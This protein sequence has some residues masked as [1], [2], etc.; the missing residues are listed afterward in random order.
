MINDYLKH[1]TLSVYVFIEE[2]IKILKATVPHISN[3]IYFTDGSTA[4]YKNYKNLSNL[5]HHQQDFGLTAEWKFYATSHGKGP[6]DGIG[7]TVKRLATRASLQAPI[8]G[9]ILTPLQ[10]YEW[11]VNELTSIKLVYVYLVNQF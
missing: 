10:L 8:H 1:D 5:C 9:Q 11:G 4:Q 6:C 7:G 3:L 2:T